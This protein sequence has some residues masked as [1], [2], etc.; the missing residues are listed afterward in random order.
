VFLFRQGGT[1]QF[2]CW[3]VN[4]QQPLRRTPV[5]VDTADLCVDIVVE[6]D[7]TWSWKDLDE[8]EHRVRTGVF[9][10]EEV[11]CVAA[12]ADDVIAQIERGDPPFDGSMNDWRPDPAWPVSQLPPD[13]DVV[14]R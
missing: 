13:W 8:Y 14:A 11:A 6:P 9:S 2:L 12:A 1:E 7:G 10:V 4:F 5:G 3:Y